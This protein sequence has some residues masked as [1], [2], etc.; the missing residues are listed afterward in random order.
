MT[1][2]EWKRRCKLLPP[3]YVKLVMQFIDEQGVD[4]SYTTVYDVIRGKNNNT[5]LTL[6]VWQAIASIQKEHQSN[7]KKARKLKELK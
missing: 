2:K 1:K 5:S 4:A 7:L 3:N 6:L